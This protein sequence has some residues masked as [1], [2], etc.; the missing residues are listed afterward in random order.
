MAKPAAGLLRR[1]QDADAGWRLAW[2]VAGLVPVAFLVVFFFWPAGTL[3]VRGFHS[4]GEW[5]LD[6]FARV[7]S[8]ARTWRILGFTLGMAA[9]ATAACL[10]LGIPGAHL[11][12]RRRFRGRALLRAVVVVPFVLPTV[13][14]GVAFGSLFDDG[15]MLGFLGLDDHWI[16]IL[17]AMVFFNFSVIVRTVGTM[18]RRLDPRLGEAALTLGASPARALFTIVLPALGPAIAAGASLTFLFCAS[19]FGIVM[20]LGGVRYSTIETEIW[21]QTTQLLDLPAAAALSITQLAVVTALLLVTNALQR[22]TRQAHR[23]HTDDL[24]V[25]PATWRRDWATIAVT[26]VVALGLVMLPLLNLALRS[27]RSR[28]DWTLRNYQ[29]L[30]GGEN[31]ALSVPVSLAVWNSLWIAAVAA[32]LALVLGVLVSLVASRRPASARGR[33]TLWAVEGLFLLPLGVSAV[34]VGFGYLITLN[35]PPLDLRSSLV[36]IPVAQALVALPLVVRSLLPAL[37]AIDSRQLEAARTLG[38]SHWRVLVTIE[39]PQL[40]RGLGLAAGFAFA[41]SLGEFGATSFLSR[42]DNPTLP[43]VIYR[44]F[45]QPGADNYGMALAAATLLAVLTGVVMAA[46]E[47]RRPKGVATW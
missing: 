19:S 15:G 46:A 37:H 13:V 36:L 44:L 24:G 34:T 39:F 45:G 1:L 7:F 10:V 22:R 17:L 41:T 31:P 11:L 16:A 18:W 26:A 40:A 20:V 8:A 4:E 23:L 2:L 3:V 32:A 9:L 12:Y 5:T 30:F 47:G 28:G 6:G 33:R 29:A 14:V 35:R 25:G 38:A 27:L 21:F 43:V 42:P